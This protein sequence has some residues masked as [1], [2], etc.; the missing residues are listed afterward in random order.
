MPR[1]A[2]ASP[3]R[4][5]ALALGLGTALAACGS[6]SDPTEP[7]PDPPDPDPV[8][9]GAIELTEVA[10]APGALTA[11]AAPPGD[12]R[13]FLVE[14]AGRIHVVDDGR[15]LDTPFLDLSDITS[16]EGE[17][18][19]LGLAFHPDYES[20]GR[21]FVDHTDPSGD[22]RVVEYRVRDDDPNR[23]D[24][25]S[26][27]E[28]LSIVQPGTNH[29]G[30]DLGFGPDGMLYVATGDGGG[31][32][33]PH[34]NAQDVGTPLGGLLRLDVSTPGDATIPPDNPFADSPDRAG[35]LWAWGL[36]NPWRF[37]FDDE[38]GLLFIADVGQHAWEEVNVAPATEPGLNYGWPIVEGPACVEEGC[39]REGLVEPAVSYSSGD[40]TSA[41]SVIG[42][43]VYRG[44]RIPHAVGHYF[45]SDL[46]GRF[47]RSFRYE[48][49]EVVEHWD[50][51][52]RVPASVYSIGQD[53]LGDL[54]VLTTDGRVFRIDPADDG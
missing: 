18:G 19:L 5:L 40:G 4:A 31:A 20:N 3:T 45:Y 1:A 37:A 23:A 26:A 9:E 22:T 43:G 6:D 35:E 52:V 28:L 11:L 53:G 16:T 42:G 2:P 48:G 32:F 36:R 44:D 51:E 7:D 38:T 21:F 47:V 54:H 29:N 39:D 15:L 46:C 33:D 12:S 25:A 14:Q 10:S 41:C 17:Q 30:G 50:W 24:P 27:A 34:G 13:L 8:P 49:G